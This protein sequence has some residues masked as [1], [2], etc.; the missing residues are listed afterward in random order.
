MKITKVEHAMPKTKNMK[1]VECKCGS[2][3]ATLDKDS[4][5]SYTCPS[6]YT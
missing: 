4:I 2:Q 1:V 6:C 3:T 5:I